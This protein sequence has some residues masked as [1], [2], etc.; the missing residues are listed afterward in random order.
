MDHV[1]DKLSDLIIDQLV[2]LMSSMWK[3][4]IILVCIIFI[5][6]EVYFST[7]HEIQRHDVSLAE[8]LG[9]ITGAV[10]TYAVLVPAIVIL[11][12]SPISLIP[13]KKFT[14]AEKLR[15][16]TYHY[17]CSSAYCFDGNLYYP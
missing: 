6:C 16:L 4:I 15:D 11:L 2:I 10:L 13:I 3:R 7:I 8:T 17:N 12:A 1:K 9:I 14:Y 5:L